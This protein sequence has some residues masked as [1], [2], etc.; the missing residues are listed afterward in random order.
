MI[1]NSIGALLI[2]GTLITAS[3]ALAQTIRETRTV[4]TT[5]GTVSEFNPQSIV[6]KSSDQSSP[7]SYT[8][9]QTITYVDENGSPIAVKEITSGRPVTVHYTKEGDQLIATKVIVRKGSAAPT[10][11]VQTTDSSTSSGIVTEF[12]PN[13]IVIK[14]GS[15]AT[16]LLYGYST[17]TIYVDDTGMLI[18][19]KMVQLGVPVTIHFVKAGNT[20]IATKIVVNTAVPSVVEDRTVKTTITTTK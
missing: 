11:I 15:S 14:S 2:T 5:E 6:I 7:V 10:V 13:T 9:S 17:E 1:R 16:P 12:G 8:S 18:S 4:T 19:R 20:Y 3:L